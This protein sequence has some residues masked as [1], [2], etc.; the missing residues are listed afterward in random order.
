MNKYV[1]KNT[2]KG[3]ELIAETIMMEM[4]TQPPL[5]ADIVLEVLD[6]LENLKPQFKT[7]HHCKNECIPIELDED[8]YEQIDYHG[9][10]SL[11]EVQQAIYEG[12]VLCETCFNK[13]GGI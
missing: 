9:V 7:C 6:N 13:E 10:E 11:Q 4:A 1:V 8:T 12:I 2:D 3:L 5:C